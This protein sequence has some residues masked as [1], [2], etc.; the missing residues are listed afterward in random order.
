MNRTQFAC[1]RCG[2]FF[3]D[4][5]ALMRHLNRKYKCNSIIIV[6]PHDINPIQVKKI[7]EITEED[8]GPKPPVKIRMKPMVDENLMIGTDM[9]DSSARTTAETA[10]MSSSYTG[11]SPIA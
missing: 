6:D 9:S 10:S 2:K 7:T 3:K 11:D 5:W 1:A 4:N 8:I